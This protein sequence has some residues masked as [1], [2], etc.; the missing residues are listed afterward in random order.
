MGCEVGAE[1]VFRW[2]GCGLGD[3]CEA[4][5]VSSPYVFVKPRSGCVTGCANALKTCLV[6]ALVNSASLGNGVLEARGIGAENDLG[7]SVD[8]AIGEE[9]AWAEL[10]IEAHAGYW[11]N[12]S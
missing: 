10:C 9:P 4:F 5:F 6:S 12:D 1:S 7:S 2:I 8:V 11:N 3:R